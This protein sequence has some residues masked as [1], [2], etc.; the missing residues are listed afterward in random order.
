MKT[1]KVISIYFSGFLVGIALVLYPAAGNIFT[2]TNYHGF[3]SAQFGSIFLPQIIVA[4]LASISAPKIASRVGMKKVMLYGLVALLL[5]MVLMALSHWFTS[6]ALDY[7]IILLGT[8]CLGGGFGFTITALNPFAYNLFPGK[9]T[10][11][12]TAMHILLGLGTSSSA[13]LLNSFLNN[14]YWMGAPL[15]VA[16]VVLIL[17][18]FTLPLPLSLPKSDAKQEEQT[19]S[20]PGRIWLYAIA[21]F[22]YGASEA[23]FGNWGA[24]FLEREGGLSVSKAALG[25]TLFWLFIAMGRVFFTFIALRFSTKW[26][27]AI[28]PFLVALVFYMLPSAHSENVLLTCMALGGLGMSFLFPKSISSTTDE[29]PKYAALVSGMMVAAIQLGTGFSAQVIGSLNGRFS[30]ATLFQFSAVYALGLGLIVVFLMFKK[31][32]HE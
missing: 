31:T 1:R 4:I 3:S 7:W 28:A 9:E 30:L 10:S 16:G 17:I 14:G 21:V 29:F 6:G 32:T 24:L 20:I 5:S 8:A 13:L 26:L 19:R 15:L 23:T 27:Y 2:D 11:A 22:F 12:V 25:L 18:L